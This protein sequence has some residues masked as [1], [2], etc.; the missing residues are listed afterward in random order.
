VNFV[1]IAACS[2]DKGF[3]NTVNLHGN[4][5]SIYER[6]DVAHSCSDYRADGTGIGEWKEVELN[7]GLKHGFLYRPLNEWVEPTVAWARRKH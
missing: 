7:T 4:I 5:L 2:A 3:L 6:S 1:L